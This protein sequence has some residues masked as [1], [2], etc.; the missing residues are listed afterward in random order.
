MRLLALVQGVRDL[1]R[2]AGGNLSEVR[3]PT[4]AVPAVGAA[5][6]AVTAQDVVATATAA[7]RAALAVRMA[8]RLSDFGSP[9]A[10]ANGTAQLR[11]ILGRVAGPETDRKEPPGSPD[12]RFVPMKP[13]GKYDE[14]TLFP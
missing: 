1:A 4:S 8:R 13:L 11:A 2:R 14:A 9:G 5:F 12:A 10:E 6:A 3:P 7:D